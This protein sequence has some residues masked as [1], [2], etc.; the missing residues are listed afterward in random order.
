MISA[1]NMACSLLQQRAVGPPEKRPDGG[2][3]PMA[4]PEQL[5][6]ELIIPEQRENALLDLSKVRE[7]CPAHVGEGAATLSLTA[8]EMRTEG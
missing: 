1:Q 4:T 2:E 6:L 8:L 5:V 7:S 3:R